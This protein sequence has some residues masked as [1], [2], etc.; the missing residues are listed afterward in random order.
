MA[1]A[2]SWE[3]LR[4]MAESTTSVVY[5]EFVDEGFVFIGPVVSFTQEGGFAAFKLH[6]CAMKEGCDPNS[7]WQICSETDFVYSEKETMPSEKEPGRIFFKTKNGGTTI[8]LNGHEVIDPAQVVG[9]DPRF[10][11]HQG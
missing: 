10:L 4:T 8:Y 9:I 2:L 3:E 5:A 7:R 1:K 11:Q 6:W